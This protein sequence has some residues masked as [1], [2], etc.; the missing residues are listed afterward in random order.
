MKLRRGASRRR[1]IPNGINLTSLLDAIFNLVFFFLLVTTLRR[2]EGQA[3]VQLPQS[4]T[5]TA[6]PAELMTISIDAS[7]RIFFADR[8]VQEADLERELE[9][10]A[11][12][13][14][15]EVTIRG[16]SEVGLGRVYAVMDICRRSG[17][18]AVS[19]QAE[20]KP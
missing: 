8:E 18:D 16:D 6:I 9:R 19:L 14:V 7:G 15:R 12:G 17:L 4:E 3:R 1:K 20:K 11:L 5:A 13:G 2:E 10:V